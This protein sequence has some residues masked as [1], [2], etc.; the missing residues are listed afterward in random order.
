MQSNIIKVTVLALSLGML[1]GCADMTQIEEA[2]AAA[3]AAMDK[4]TDAYN[5]AQSSHTIASEA[6]Y[7]AQQAQST[8]E[9]ALECCNANSSKLD[10]MF[11]KAMMK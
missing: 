5:L 7:S 3:A 10:R 11:Q 8:A 2:K 9:A 1:G 6:A 4:A